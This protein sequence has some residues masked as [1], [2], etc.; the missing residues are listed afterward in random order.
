MMA[1][2]HAKTDREKT[3]RA[4]ARRPAGIALCNSVNLTSSRHLDGECRKYFYGLATGRIRKPFNGW[5]SDG[6]SP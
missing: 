1:S 5:F 2:N 6:S 3:G 4:K